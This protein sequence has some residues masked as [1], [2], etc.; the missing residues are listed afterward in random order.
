MTF[1]EINE[2]L[3]RLRNEIDDLEEELR[4]MTETDDP[5]GEKLNILEGLYCQYHAYLIYSFC[6]GDRVRH[7]FEDGTIVHHTEEWLVV[8]FDKG[9]YKLFTACNINELSK[10]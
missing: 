7:D 10:I 3:E 8:S 5:N 2:Q 4:E 9:Y 6:A 1:N